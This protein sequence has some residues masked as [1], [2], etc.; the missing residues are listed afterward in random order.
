MTMEPG[1]LEKMIE[2]YIK[3]RDKKAAIK[4]VQEAALKEYTDAMVSI[5]DFLKAH[6]QTQ[7]VNSVSCPAGTAFIKRKRSATMADKGVFR[8]FVIS[9]NNFDLCD[10]SAK[11]EAVEDYVKEHDGQL[12]PGV[13]YSSYEGVNIQ[14]K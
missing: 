1:T 7:G 14:R 12:P 3:L 6:L 4:K 2:S 9:T 5:E 10:M 11:V 8:E 13:N